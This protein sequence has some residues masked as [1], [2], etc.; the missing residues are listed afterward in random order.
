MCN[1]G[2]GWRQDLCGLHY[3]CLVRLVAFM[4][5]GKNFLAQ[6]LSFK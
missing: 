1:A 6:S 2:F 5:V 3:L 4:R